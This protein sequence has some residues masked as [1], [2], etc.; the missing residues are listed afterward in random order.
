M[1]ALPF[2]EYDSQHLLTL[3]ILFSDRADDI[4]GHFWLTPLHYGG[5]WLHFHQA[6]DGFAGW[7]ITADAAAPRQITLAFMPTAFSSF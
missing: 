2:S 5:H 3:L 7:L 6:I 1:R 4:E